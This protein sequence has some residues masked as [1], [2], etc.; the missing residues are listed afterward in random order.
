MK[1]ISIC[2][3]ALTV[4][5]FLPCEAFCEKTS[6][7]YSGGVIS[8]DQPTVKIGHIYGVRLSPKVQTINSSDEYIYFPHVIE[9]LGNVTNKFDFDIKLKAPDG[10]EVA[11]LKD[12]NPYGVN[13]GLDIKALSNPLELSESSFT[14]VILRL[15]RPPTAKMGDTVTATLRVTCRTKGGKSYTGYNGV[16]YGGDPFEQALDTVIVK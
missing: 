12:N 16:T 8:L 2:I 13:Q 14:R 11:L 1:Q 3:I 5:S 4:I 6:I 15:K 9:N 7:Y 10:W